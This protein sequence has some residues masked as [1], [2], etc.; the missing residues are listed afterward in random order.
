MA[1]GDRTI[2]SCGVSPARLI[3]ADWPIQMPVRGDVSAVVMPMLRDDS[4]SLPPGR[5]VSSTI[6]SGCKPGGWVEFGPPG[7]GRGGA[8]KKPPPPPPPA[9]GRED[10]YPARGSWVWEAIGRE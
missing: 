3:S 2:I 7:L 5:I 1:T 4:S 10:G 9:G 8:A 6:T